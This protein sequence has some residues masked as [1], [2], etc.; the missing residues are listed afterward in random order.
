MQ[1][2]FI[3]PLLPALPLQPPVKLPYSLN[4]VNISLTTMLRCY[5]KR[6]NLIY[7]KQKIILW[8]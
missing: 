4:I 2:Y 1:N 3:I 5:K 8:Q 7:L 6:V